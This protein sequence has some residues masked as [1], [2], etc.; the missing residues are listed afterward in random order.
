MTEVLRYAGLKI[1]LIV[2]DCEFRS[3]TEELAILHH[4]TNFIDKNLT[5]GGCV[6][7]KTFWNRLLEEN[8]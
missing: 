1:I 2:I 4:L 6:I 7:F 5:L 3:C 8:S